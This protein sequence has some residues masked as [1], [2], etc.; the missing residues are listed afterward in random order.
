MVMDSTQDIIRCYLD[1][2]KYRK[3]LK[4]SDSEDEYDLDSL[5]DPLDQTSDFGK[6]P[7]TLPSPPTP[8]QSPLKAHLKKLRGS[9]VKLTRPSPT[10]SQ[11][12][13]IELSF[14]PKYDDDELMDTHKYVNKVPEYISTSKEFEKYSLLL[15]SSTEKLMKQLNAEKSKNR[16]LELRIAS[17]DNNKFQEQVTKGDYDLLKRQF[18]SLKEKTDQMLRKNREYEN[19]SMRLTRENLLLREKLIKYKQLYERSRD[20]RSTYNPDGLLG[21]SAQIEGQHKQQFER[22][23]LRSGSQEGNP[24]VLKNDEIAEERR[25]SPLP[26]K[27]TNID[28]AQSAIQRLAELLLQSNNEQAQ[29]SRYLEPHDR[30]ESAANDPATMDERTIPAKYQEFQI[31]Q[32]LSRLVQSVEQIS[33]DLEQIKSTVRQEQELQPNRDRAVDQEGTL[34]SDVSTFH[35]VNDAG[36]SQKN[37]GAYHNTPRGSEEMYAKSGLE[38]DCPHS[39]RPSSSCSACAKVY[40]RISRS[41]SH[42]TTKNNSHL[43]SNSYLE[44]NTQ[45]LMGR[46]M[47]NRTI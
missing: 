5:V 7:M 36:Y 1:G 16:E 30:Q 19:D 8:H 14:F 33:K 2:G 47:W 18:A 12:E 27:D 13:G 41:P 6:V 34:P 31:N 21:F 28:D 4:L 42:S 20:S 9:P 23:L 40:Q 44:G 11:E 3:S 17:Y 37:I 29:S 22:H 39:E 24:T 32:E 45:S 15:A 10:K 38:N 43:D 35:S 26:T 25:S 46:Y